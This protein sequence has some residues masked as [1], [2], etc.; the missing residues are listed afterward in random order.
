[1]WCLPLVDRAISR[2]SLFILGKKDSR[3][4]SSIRGA[5]ATRGTGK[6]NEGSWLERPTL[7]SNRESHHG[8]LMLKYNTAHDIAEDM[9]DAGLAS[10][11]MVQRSR[12]CQ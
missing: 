12:T 3:E 9:L 2:T 5:I 6:V 8:M 1:M 11:T 4:L 7:V 10:V